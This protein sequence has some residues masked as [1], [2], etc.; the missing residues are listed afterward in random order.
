MMGQP[1]CSWLDSM[2]KVK[3]M[4]G[5]VIEWGRDG[6][7]ELVHAFCDVMKRECDSKDYVFTWRFH[8]TAKEACQPSYNA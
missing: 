1:E 4:C 7:E 8:I 5:E 2:V 3:R 6:K